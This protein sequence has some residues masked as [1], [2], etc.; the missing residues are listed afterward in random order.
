MTAALTGIRVVDFGQYIAAP[1]TGLL[2]ADHGADVVRIDPPGGPRL[3]GAADGFYNRG[4]RRIT[5]DLKHRADLDVARELVR[6]ADVVVENFRPGVMDRLGLGYD[7]A[8][9]ANARLVYC[10]IPGFAADDRRASVPGWEGVVL[11]AGAGYRPI[12]EHWDP[13]GRLHAEIDD[14]GRPIFFD[15]PLAS[16]FGGF[17]GAMAVVMALI[18]R[19]RSGSGQRVE[20]PLVEAFAEAWSSLLGM[21]KLVKDSPG[22]LFPFALSNVSFRCADGRHLDGAPLRHFFIRFLEA[23][24]VADEWR[25][26]GLLEFGAGPPDPILQ[27]QRERRFTTLIAGRPARVWDQL[28][29]DH[30]LPFAMVRTPQEWMALEPARASGT[31]VELDDPEFGPTWMAG[32]AVQVDDPGA[33]LRPRHRPDADRAGVLAELDGPAPARIDAGGGERDLSRPL[34]G[35]VVVDLTQ[36]VAGPTA[37]RILADFGAQVVKVNNPSPSANDAFM[38]HHNRGKRT[39][40]L[41][42]ADPTGQEVLWRL[43]DDADVVLENFPPGRADRYGFGAEAVRIRRPD[44][45]YSSISAFPATEA[46]GSRRGYENQA[47]AATGISARYAGPGRWPLCLPHLINDAS[48]GLLGAFATGLALLRRYR[49]GRGGQ[50]ATSLAQAATLNQGA[51]LFLIT[52]EG[53]AGEEPSG[54]AGFG[55]NALQ[56]LYRAEDGWFF[57]GA[58][59]D[60]AADLATVPGLEGLTAW[61]SAPDPDG[62]LAGA[63]AARF[64]TAPLSRWIEPLRTGGIGAAPV[65]GFDQAALELLKRNVVLLHVDADGEEIPMP[66]IGRWLSATPAEAGPDPGPLGSQT[67][68]VVVEL[69]CSGDQVAAL[70]ARGVLRTPADPLP[71]TIGGTGCGSPPARPPSLSLHC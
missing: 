53:A 59:F 71:E 31:I 68:D 45:V 50:T 24:G 26:D 52:S 67:I 42:I 5:L 63:L 19:E 33:A 1:L 38:G 55:W 51:Y 60:Q 21:R 54:V 35:L 47:S 8:S 70:R 27:E 16:T 13:T 64:A 25:A 12:A 18:A 6:R 29:V 23:A 32:W 39:I 61:K 56:R 44:I 4:K 9:R 49:T 28:A 34:Q 7:V 10:S 22:A 30:G 46:W 62:A 15:L 69:G 40:L 2:L 57:L 43:I 3:A 36:V 17:S 65:N 20:V 11:A 58:R 14:P 48:T 37:G 41:D 66:G